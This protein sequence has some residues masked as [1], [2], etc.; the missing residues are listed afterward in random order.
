MGKNAAKVILI[1]L[2]ILAAYSLLCQYC[3]I[4]DVIQLGAFLIHISTIGYFATNPDCKTPKAY[5][6]SFFLVLII[7][8]SICTQS[9]SVR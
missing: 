4:S 9:V 2:C 1:Q 3:R 8:F 6:V 5:W 7:G